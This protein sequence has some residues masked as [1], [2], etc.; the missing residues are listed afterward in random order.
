MPAWSGLQK[1]S[2]VNIAGGNRRSLSMRRTRRT[3][4]GTARAMTGRDE[5]SRR[6]ISRRASP[7]ST[8]LKPGNV[9][10][11]APGHGMSVADFVRSAEASAGPVAHDGARVGARVRGAVDGDPAAVGQNTNLG[12]MLL[13]APLAA[14]A[15]SATARCAQRSPR[16][17]DDLDRADA[18]DVFAAIVAANP[19]G[20]GRAAP[21]RR[22]APAAVTLREAMAEA[23]GARPHRAPIRH[24]LRGRVSCSALPRCWR[25]PVR[26]S[27]PRWRDARC[28]SC[29]SRRDARHAYRAQIRRG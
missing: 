1:V 21:A 5:R 19:G 20:L 7:N 3:A 24:R 27:D 6:P 10:R 15:E 2:A 11:F 14:A 28:L 29:L 18:A 22:A 26:R 23:R 9:H 13:C 17:L 12:I 25:R 16:V 8:R 4:S